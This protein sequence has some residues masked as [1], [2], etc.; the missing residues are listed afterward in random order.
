MRLGAVSHF[1]QGWSPAIL[2]FAREMGVGLL[3]DGVSWG[4]IEPSAGRFVFEGGASLYPET[5]EK[6]GIEQIVV[7]G[8]PEAHVDGGATPYTERGRAAFAEFVA[9]V[10]ERFPSIDAVEIG[11]EFNGQNFVSGPVKAAG[12]GARA[13]H[14]ADLLEAVHERIADDFPR[15]AILGGATH[16]VPVGYLRDTFE[17]GALAHSDGVAVHPYTSKPEHLGE[18]LALLRAAMGRDLQPI[19]VTEFGQA[20]DAPED[21][22]A[23]L[24]KMVA[25]MSA[26]GV[27]A[28]T[29]Y[30]LREQP[31]FPNMELLGHD[32]A[33]TP[34][35]ESFAFM[36]RLLARGDAVEVS[37]DG[38]TH[39]FRFGDRAMMLWGAER[40][41]ALAPG[42]VAYS[43]SGERLDGAPRLSDD[44]PL[45]VIAD[46]PI[47]LGREV[48]LGASPVVG[49]SFHQF[50]VTNAADG[51][52]RFEGPWSWHALRGDGRMAELVTAEGG[53]RPGEIWKPYLGGGPFRH[54]L[55]ASET[56]VRPVEFGDGANPATR[57]D[58]L[59]RF[60]APEA[61]TV[62]IRGEWDVSPETVDGVDLTVLVG[63]E[64]V[65]RGVVRD[66][67]DLALDGLA[68]ARGEAI[69]FV[70]GVNRDS[71]GDMT[72]R[73]IRI[74]RDE[75][76]LGPQVGGDGA[77]APQPEPRP[78]PAPARNAPPVVEVDD[79]VLR[80]GA[81]RRLEKH[82]R[83]EDADGDAAQRY[84]IEDPS[85]GARV[86]MAGRAVDA[87]DGHVL[88][89]GDLGA[90][91]VG[92]GASGE[93]ETLRLRAH[94]GTRWG[95]WDSFELRPS[96]PRPPAAASPEPAAPS[97]EA[98]DVVLAPGER[99]ALAD[100]LDLTAGDAPLRSFQIRDAAGGPSLWLDG[101]GGV[102][103]AVDASGGRF[104]G[105]NA[106]ARLRVQGDDR[107]SSHAMSV[108]ALDG[109]S[110]SAWESFTVTTS[111]DDIA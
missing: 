73:R 62:S 106:L 2:P 59:E 52:A 14:Y 69:D 24:A 70:L 60:T 85:G 42:A 3:R 67:L 44:E 104:F 38:L 83:V 111:L 97:A 13:G 31:W 86:L 105:T 48:R 23:Y 34:A 10:L 51:S 37:P 89:A 8:R 4:R 16:S 20:F 77:A 98:R 21:A 95:A 90:L 43:A 54:P 22:P 32:G 76:E 30:A 68:V 74:L 6:A 96:A 12:Y 19:Y 84:E 47:A 82:V 9:A 65:W 66:A 103:A 100:L 1:N 45:V 63:G 87:E 28:A 18:H 107:P 99:V 75:P 29:W 58:V 50:D 64:R 57:F 102:D 15:V 46:R 109:E 40:E 108:Q 11:N 71:E 33:R 93:A 78:E 80:P 27:E 36:Q 26:A 91:A 25:V 110:R 49:D 79:L 56:G 17:R 72:E 88:D 53:E 101:A 92:L 94:D 35:G 5:L 39:A 61:M 41:A 81:V 55:L 7:F